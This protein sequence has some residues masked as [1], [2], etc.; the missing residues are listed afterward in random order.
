MDAAITMKRSMESD[1]GREGEITVFR[2]WWS[3]HKDARVTG[4]DLDDEVLAA[5]GA[6]CTRKNVAYY[7]RPK[8]GERIGGFVLHRGPGE[9]AHSSA[10]YWL[11]LTGPAPPEP[12]WSPPPKSETEGWEYRVME[13]SV[14]AVLARL[15]Q[16][17]VSVQ[18]RDGKAVFKA[19]A[20]P[21]ADIVALID[22]RKADISAFL[23]PDAV[24]RRPRG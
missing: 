16:S 11:E 17:D 20:A 4:S 21:P 23:H 5:M 22:A 7:L 8:I 24:Q 10:V 14:P 18:W 3:R 9:Y 19:A 1:P 15:A 2:T 6:K 13:D 12:E